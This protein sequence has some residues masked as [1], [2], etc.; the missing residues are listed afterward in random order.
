MHLV[1]TKVVLT[2]LNV[3]W[4]AQ[5]ILQGTVKGKRRKDRQKKRS[6]DN[7]KEWTGMNFASSVGALE[8]GQIGKRLLRSRLWSP[9]NL[10]RLWYRLN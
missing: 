1:K 3:L 2:H 8:I 4:L 5:T 10:A 7:I 9:D 6:E